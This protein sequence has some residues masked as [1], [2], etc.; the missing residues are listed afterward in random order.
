M[1]QRL[2]R[3]FNWDFIRM[4]KG[5]EA[6]YSRCAPYWEPHLECTRAFIA[7]HMRPGGRLAI[8]GAGRLLD[9]D[10]KLLLDNFSEIHLF[11][12]DPTVTKAWRSESGREFR[13]RVVPRVVDVT[14]S[15]ADWSAGLTAPIR[16]GELTAYLDSLQPQKGGWESEGFDG[17]ISLNLVSQIPI[18]WR[19]RV[20]AAA[21]NLSEDAE[22]AL[23]RSMARLQSAHI[24]AVRKQP[25]SWSII[26]T[27]TEYY[28]YTVDRSE[29]DVEGAL[30]GDVSS[31]LSNDTPRMRKSGAD[32]W[33]WH[34]VPQFIESDTEGHI[35]RVEASSW[36][37]AGVEAQ[38]P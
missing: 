12:A 19:D 7:E 29:W 14:G 23:V 37:A 16:H 5:I 27:D 30:Y 20:L 34:L 3:L 1:I 2:A 9:V 25:R 32:Q 36:R 28:T 11:D 22:R 26:I 15:L 24:N 8:L 17:V 13:H 35:H 18:Y 31:E 33:L 10:L 4:G 38:T 21:P 6:R